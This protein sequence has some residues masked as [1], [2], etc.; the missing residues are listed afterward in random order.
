MFLVILLISCLSLVSGMTKADLSLLQ[1]PFLE[2]CTRFTRPPLRI[3]SGA[4]LA[5]LLMQFITLVEVPVY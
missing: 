1:E 3:V 5:K 2:L 4:N